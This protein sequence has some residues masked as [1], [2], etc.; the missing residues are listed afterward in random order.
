[1][2]LETKV[3][4]ADVFVG[5]VGTEAVQETLIKVFEA[6]GAKFGGLI[7]ELVEF[8]DFFEAGIIRELAPVFEI[9]IT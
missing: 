9:K 1:M 5:G 6:L 3:L 7:G 2:G 4:V 8:E